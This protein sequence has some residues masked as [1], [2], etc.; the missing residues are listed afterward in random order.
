MSYDARDTILEGARTEPIN[1]VAG[2]ANP[3]ARSLPPAAPGKARK[4]LPAALPSGLTT[5]RSTAEP[6]QSADG[7]A[8]AA[9]REFWRGLNAAARAGVPRPVARAVGD[10]YEA[11]VAVALAH[12]EAAVV[13]VLDTVLG[14]LPDLLKPHLEGLDTVVAVRVGRRLEAEAEDVRAELAEQLGELRQEIQTRFDA[15]CALARDEAIGLRTL[16]ETLLR[17]LPAPQVTVEAPVVHV[18]APPAPDVVLPEGAIRATVQLPP[19]RKRVTTKRVEY[20]GTTGRPSHIVEEET[21][22]DDG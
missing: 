20:D 1:S 9:D 7:R 8:A 6:E 17:Q 12:V 5:R 10:A 3:P 19:P 15:A 2:S 18:A 16:L 11:A 13:A 4:G 22:V 14:H 21:E